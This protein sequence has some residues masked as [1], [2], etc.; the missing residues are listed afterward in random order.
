MAQREVHSSQR[1]QITVEVL[2]FIDKLV[3]ATIQTA[4]KT[5]DLT[6]LKKEELH[7]TTEH[8]G[9]MK[10]KT[11]AI[12]VRSVAKTRQWRLKR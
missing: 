7:R 2:Q 9:L 8:Q 1:V 12:F 4:Q 11:E 6:A 5:D 3:G 10:A